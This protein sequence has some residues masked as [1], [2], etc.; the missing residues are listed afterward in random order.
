MLFK[1][2]GASHILTPEY[3]Q[4]QSEVM[5][6]QIVHIVKGSILHWGD[7]VKSGLSHFNPVKFFI[8][9]FSMRTIFEVSTSK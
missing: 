2:M 6:T 1:K 7:I 3:H 4:K 9:K 5:Q 8:L